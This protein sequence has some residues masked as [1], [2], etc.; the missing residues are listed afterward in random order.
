MSPFWAAAT[1]MG[2]SSFTTWEGRERGCTEFSPAGFILDALISTYLAEG[3]V[4]QVERS[5]CC[6]RLV[7]GWMLERG[8]R[9]EKW[10]RKNEGGA[11]RE[12]VQ[13]VQAGR[14]ELFWLPNERSNGT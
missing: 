12:R 6:R 4:A 8:A 9:M 7:T 5:T 1:R 14:Q 3:R 13:A 11:N 10:H 2:S